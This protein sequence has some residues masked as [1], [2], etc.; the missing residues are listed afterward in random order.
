MSQTMY[1]GETFEH[2]THKFRVNFETDLDG[3]LPWNEEDGHG[4]VSDWTTRAKSPGEIV[5]AVDRP[6]RRYYN[7]AEAVKIARRDKW[8]APPYGTGTAGEQAV[9]AVRADFERLRDF[10][11]D[12]WTYVGVIVTLLDDYGD[13]MEGAS[14]SLWRLESDASE[15]LTETANELA[16]DILA[17]AAR[18]LAA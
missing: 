6:H 18:S 8:D 16:A 10:C 14:A 7:F 5:L 9:R 15:Y 12:Y 4:P 17:D 3:G 2:A 13:P 11:N 1:D